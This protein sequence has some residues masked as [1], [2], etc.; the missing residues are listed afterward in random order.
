VFVVCVFDHQLSRI[1]GC[2]MKIETVIEEV[3]VVVL[4]TCERACVGRAVYIPYL[5]NI[6]GSDLTS[7]SIHCGSA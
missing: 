4:V 2:G 1:I 5:A 7:T 3:E 6:R